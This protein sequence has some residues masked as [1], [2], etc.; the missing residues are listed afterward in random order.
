[1]NNDSKSE[2][3]RKQDEEFEKSLPISRELFQELFD[4]L[5]EALEEGCND[6]LR[7]T[8]TFLHSQSVRNVEEVLLWLNDKGGYCDC[9]V[10]ANVEELFE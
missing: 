10:L 4:Y 6:T 3:R 1:M 5:D 8:E 7:L 2:F 9:E